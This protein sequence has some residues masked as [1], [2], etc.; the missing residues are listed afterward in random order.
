MAAKDTGN[1]EGIDGTIPVQ[2]STNEEALTVE[3]SSGLM[4]IIGRGIRSAV[5]AVDGAINFILSNNIMWHCMHV[6]MCMMLLFPSYY[7]NNIIIQSAPA[8]I[9][10]TITDIK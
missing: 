8:Y 1:T 3:R 6:Y 5:D 10:S 9:Y 7:Y 4:T 2:H